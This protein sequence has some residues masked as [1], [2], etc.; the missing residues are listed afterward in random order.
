MTFKLTLLAA[1]AVSALN[2]GVGKL[3]V[4]G[5]DTWNAFACGYDGALAL[6]QAS[7]MKSYGL[8]D[9]GYNTVRLDLWQ[10]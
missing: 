5:Y 9:A 7:L 8:V 4:M 1:T 10:P 6:E 2:T 3:P